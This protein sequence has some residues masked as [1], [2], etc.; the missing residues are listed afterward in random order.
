MI[1]NK[2]FQ[3][4]LG[5]KHMR[6]AASLMKPARD[7]FTGFVTEGSSGVG[8]GRGVGTGVGTGVG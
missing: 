5:D 8:S 6:S 4:V 2:G 3:F 1:S 7:Y